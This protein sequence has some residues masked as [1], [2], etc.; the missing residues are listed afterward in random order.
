MALKSWSTT[1]A[2]NDDADLASGLDFR[3]NWNPA[4]VNN[5]MRALMTQVK[6]WWDDV[7]GGTYSGGTAGGTGNAHTLTFT[8]TVQTLAAGMRFAYLAPG[9]AT[10]AVTLN[11]DGQGA[12][13]LQWK[14]AALTSGDITSG[15]LIIV[16]YDGTQ[17]QLVLPPRNATF[18]PSSTY[19]NSLTTDATIGAM[20]DFLPFVDVSDSNAAN[21]GTVQ[22][23]LTNV[24]ANMTADT[25]GG[26]TGDKLMFSDASESGAAQTVTIDNLLANSL[27][28][29][30]TDAS[31]GDLNDLIPF[32]DSSESNVANKC[33]MG[34]YLYNYIANLTAETAPSLTNDYIMIRNASGSTLKK[35]A[36]QYIGIG[37]QTVWV[38]AAAMTSRTTNG[39]A[40]GT[41][42]STTNK[43]MNKVLD[44]DTTTQEFAQFT[45]AFPKNWNE[46]TVTFIPYW[47]AA[48]GS[49]G[50]VFGL[51]GVAVSND[52]VIDAAFGT[53]QTST[54]TLIA[55]TDVHVGPESS[56]ITI[57]GT[58]AEG[59]IVYFQINRTVADA[60]DTLAADARL[61]GIK[62]IYTT[63]A[64]T[65]D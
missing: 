34:N 26:A 25:T 56:A 47:T 13:A 51:A 46:G 53:A 28:L 6:K 40:S 27:Q 20:G 30:T 43:V 16:Y 9:S 29:L 44:F 4:Q 64:N 31:A 1:D 39:A 58:P 14:G 41:T 10:G 57:A 3:E 18:S 23:F 45:I 12:K 38:P 52:D 11:V 55:T 2:D 36:P 59:D 35:I 63:N 33:T 37:K 5:S 61:I 19:L 50:V 8:N 54:D 60:S 22:D 49:G 24:M 32:M 7:D 65:D 15:D 21:K 17:F 62:L 48:S 42:E